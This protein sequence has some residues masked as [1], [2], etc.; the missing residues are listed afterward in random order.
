MFTKNSKCISIFQEFEIEDMVIQTAL[1]VKTP[2]F[3]RGASL[4]SFTDILSLKF[5]EI[6]NSIQNQMNFIQIPLFFIFFISANAEQ[7]KEA[8]DP[9][10]HVRGGQGAA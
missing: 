5:K 2:P 3:P 4:L 7:G 1:L 10:I 8:H 6:E 9:Q